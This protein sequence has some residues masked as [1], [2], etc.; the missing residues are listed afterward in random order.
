MEQAAMAGYFAALANGQA[1]DAV[2]TDLHAFQKAYL[3]GE[4]NLAW[5]YDR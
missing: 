2:T 4:G 1:A 5:A 3:D